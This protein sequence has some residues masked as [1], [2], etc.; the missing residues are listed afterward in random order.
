MK[1]L[2]NGFRAMSTTSPGNSGRFRKRTAFS[3]PLRSS[4]FSFVSQA[5][6]I[7]HSRLRRKKNLHF[8]HNQE[9]GVSGAGDI[10]G[11]TVSRD[12]AHFTEEFAGLQKGEEIITHFEIERDGDLVL[13]L[14]DE[15]HR[16]KALEYVGMFDKGDGAV[17][18]L[19]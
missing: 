3:L 7:A 4:L 13:S 11:S 9:L 19:P 6:G 18:G 2:R 17:H 15:K 12:Y 1:R 16:I 10:S 8:P 14:F 5:R